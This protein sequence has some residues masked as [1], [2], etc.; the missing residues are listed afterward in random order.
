MDLFLVTV[1]FGFGIGL[2]IGMTGMG[3]AALMTPL[4]I[5]V[6]GVKPVTA[7]GTDITYAAVTKTVGGWRHLKLKNVKLGLVFWLAIGSVPGAISGVWVIQILKSAYGNKINTIAMAMIAGTLLIFGCALLIRALFKSQADVGDERAKLDRKHKI[8]AVVLGAI[9][10]FVVGITSVGSGTLVAVILIVIYKL[11]PRRVVGTD[12]VHA[13]VLLWAAGLAHLGV[14]NVD[15]PLLLTILTGSLPGVWVGSHLTTRL[16]PGVLRI[17]ISILMI[18]S[19]LALLSKAGFVD[20]SPYYAL[21]IPVALAVIAILVHYLRQIL[22]ADKVSGQVETEPSV[23]GFKR[24]GITATGTLNTP[25][26]A[27][28]A[29]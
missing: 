22:R 4:L 5:L 21:V 16:P 18:G 28:I 24:T 6:F 23:T 8:L 9:T 27:R 12:V 7:I 29:E 14:G 26:P 13:A 19:G 11:A 25:E 10:G 15:I 17:A 3:G 20:F 2:L 1:I